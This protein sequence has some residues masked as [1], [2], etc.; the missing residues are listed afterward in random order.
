MGFWD[1]KKI[2][3]TGGAG[4]L[5]AAVVENLVQRRKVKPENVI[6]PRSDTSDL[7]VWENCVK[8]VYGVDV[9][10]HLAGRGGGIWFN[11]KHPGMLFYDNIV[12]NS[13]L[14]EASRLAASKSLW[15]SVLSAPTRSLCQCPSKKRRFGMGTPR[16]QT[17]PTACRRK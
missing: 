2:L 10:L 1:N 13:Q 5:G 11:R 4:F 14:M 6:V 7:R 9:V 17:L 12:M 15:E 16:R 3:V 8:A